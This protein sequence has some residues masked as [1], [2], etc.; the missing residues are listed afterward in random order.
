MLNQLVVYVSAWPVWAQIGG[1][2]AV[3]TW[4]PM[5]LASSAAIYAV[6]VRRSPQYVLTG[7]ASIVM[8]FVMSVGGWL[9]LLPLGI[10]LEYDPHCRGAGVLFPGQRAWAIAK[11]LIEAEKASPRR[12]PQARK[13]RLVG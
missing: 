11:A 13:L 3:L 1:G 6:T 8:F 5:G 12:Q 10:A 4:I 2:T 9:W 7:Y